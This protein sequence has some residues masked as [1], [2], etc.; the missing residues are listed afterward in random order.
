ME[1]NLLSPD[2]EINVSEDVQIAPH[3]GDHSEK[4]SGQKNL[5]L[6]GKFRF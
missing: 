4:Q 3:F 5:S 2:W 1:G 6:D